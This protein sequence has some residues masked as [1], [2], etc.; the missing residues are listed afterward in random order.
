[1]GL[2][3]SPSLW[4]SWLYPGAYGDVYLN[5]NSRAAYLP[6]YEPGSLGW[7]I[8]I[9]EIGHVLG[10]KHPHDD[11]GT[12]SP[13]L[14]EIGLGNI[15]VDWATIMSYNDS[16]YS[17]YSGHPETPMFLD[18]L[19]LQA[20]YGSNTSTNA[21]NTIHRLVDYNNTYQTIWDASGTDTLDLSGVNKGWHIELPDEIIMP[22][23]SNLTGLAAPTYDY[24]QIENRLYNGWS[25]TPSTVVWLIG[26]YED[27]IGSRY[28]D[29][30][31]GNR[32]NNYIDGGSGVDEC[33]LIGGLS[34]Y[35]IE[36]FGGTQNKIVIYDNVSGRGGEDTYINVENF[37]FN[38]TVYSYS[39]L[40]ELATPD[41]IQTTL[42]SSSASLLE[43]GDK[44]YVTLT[45]DENVV[46]NG[47]AGVTL[48]IG[49]ISKTAMYQSGS[50]SSSLLFSYT[51][52]DNLSFDKTVNVNIGGSYLASNIAD[53][54]GNVANLAGLSGSLS[55]LKINYNTIPQA[56]NGAYS[57][58]EDLT[59]TGHLPNATDADGDQLTY[60]LGNVSPSHGVLQISSDGSFSY[61]P[62]DDYFGYDSFTYEVNDGKANSNIA[63]IT[64]DV[65]AINDA[66]VAYSTSLIT[67]QD[68]SLYGSVPTATDVDSASLTYQLFGV[69]PQ[70]GELVF[71][72]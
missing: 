2:F 13:T 49:G 25:Y 63:T 48:D 53:T 59:L 37:N 44:L 42:T 10:L 8:L 67:D 15:D 54:A 3:P 50:G 19:A 21:G 71:K 16:S 31:E 38:E 57:V 40:A 34:D 60:Q 14:A 4:D 72:C 58:D 51:I 7:S 1:M 69:L 17:D 56:V 30:F 26:D 47:S 43:T 46:L 9:H 55:N 39:Q 27:V 12:S 23:V 29:V 28:N 33:I 68:D 6:S 52:E 41:L 65:R 18:V 11:G 24:D 32:F 36:C 35:D 5:L 64:I 62:D 70:H 22:T 61:T 20:L 66:P 45:F